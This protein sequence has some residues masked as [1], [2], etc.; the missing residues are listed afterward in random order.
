M[1]VSSHWWII[2]FQQGENIVFLLPNDIEFD[3]L[4]INRAQREINKFP[5]KNLVDSKIFNATHFKQFQTSQSE[6]IMKIARLAAS[7]ASTALV[8]V[9][10]V[11]MMAVD[12]F[13]NTAPA[14]AQSAG[15]GVNTL[16]GCFVNT[17]F[18]GTIAFNPTNIRQSPS[19]SA[20]IVG[21]F[22]SVGQV[23][24]FSG[25]TTGTSVADAWDGQQDN[26][27]YRLSDGRGW[28]ASAVTKG[29]PPR[30]TTPTGK[31]NTFFNWAV[32]QR[33]IS[34]YD[35]GPEF[36]GQCV[37]LVVRYLQ[38]VYFGGS[39]ASRAYGHGKDVARGVANQHANLFQFKTSGTPKRGAIISFLG[40]GYDGYYG[41]VGIVLETSGTSIKI[42]ESNYDGRATQSVVRI[43]DW[44]SRAGVI[45]W[46]DPIN[47]LP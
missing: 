28:V 24:N 27:W 20:A 37:T 38:D 29:Y 25:I 15:Q 22:T 44:K 6:L 12:S 1:L 47:A 19:T 13:V 43:S 26:M 34:R 9:S 32:G 31:A 41:H 45:G 3:N 21:K 17:S 16:R 2:F 35:L 40:S 11:G 33:G 18:T 4:D 42:L 46:A 8:T 30:C 10:S 7:L 23:V 36:N 14:Q 39:R 5:T